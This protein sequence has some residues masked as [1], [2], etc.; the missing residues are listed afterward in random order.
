MIYKVARSHRRRIALQCRIHPSMNLSESQVHRPTAIS[1][2]TRA[3]KSVKTF[4]VVTGVFII[5]YM[6]FSTTFMLGTI[7]CDGLCIPLE[8]F[9]ILGDLVSLS[10][11]L[12]P[13]IYNKLQNT[14][15]NKLCMLC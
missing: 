10:S 4:A 12:N 7:L 14:I 6:P 13:F 15:V 8:L 9:I 2:L 5:C 3:F 11:V 1:N